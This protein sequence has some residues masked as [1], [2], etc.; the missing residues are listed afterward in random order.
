MV[1][2]ISV[3]DCLRPATP[4]SGSG[5]PARPLAMVLVHVVAA[6]GRGG[7]T[8]MKVAIAGAAVTAAV[9]SWTQA[10]AAHRRPDHRVVPAVVGGHGRWPRHRR[11]AG[12][13]AVHRRRASCSAWRPCAASTPWP[14]ARTWPAGSGV[15]SVVDRLVI[16]VAVVLLAGAATAMAGPIA[17]VG[18]IVPHGVRAVVGPDYRFVLP[19]SIGYGALLVVLADVVGRV[20]LP[21]GEVQVGIMTAVVGAPVFLQL[22]RRGRM[23]ACERR[24][25]RVTSEVL[26]LRASTATSCR[27][28]GRPAGG[29]RGV[30]RGWW[31]AR[32]S[33]SVAAFCAARWAA[34]SRSPCRTSSGSS[35][36]PTSRAPA[37]S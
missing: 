35:P 28:C 27:P 31:R 21:P 12:R 33:P 16:G 14:S 2:A 9:T 23:G 13:A 17:F 22:V 18:L 8:P 29:R 24:A 36:G 11:A 25:R 37:T 20:V 26:L 7:T 1:L 3:F 15:A 30:R 32:P 10:R 19:L 4:T 5:S 34:T 6:L